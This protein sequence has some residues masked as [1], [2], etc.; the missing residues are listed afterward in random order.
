MRHMVDD[1][2]CYT[3]AEIS[4]ARGSHQTGQTKEKRKGR[5]NIDYAN[6]LTV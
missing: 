2:G 1:A 6:F 3:Y 5:I 4:G